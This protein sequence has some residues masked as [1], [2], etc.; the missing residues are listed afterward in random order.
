M[1]WAGSRDA[2]TPRTDNSKAVNVPRSEG[3]G[4]GGAAL[5]PEGTGIVVEG[6]LSRNQNHS[7]KAGRER[8]RSTLTSPFITCPPTPASVSTDPNH[9]KSEHR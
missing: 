7:A 1:V 2:E 4:K 3:K 5:R 6:F 9:Q 8:G